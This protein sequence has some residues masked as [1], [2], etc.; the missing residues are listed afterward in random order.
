V[1]EANYETTNKNIKNK[2]GDNGKLFLKK[3]VTLMS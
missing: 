1:T 2:K 3:Y